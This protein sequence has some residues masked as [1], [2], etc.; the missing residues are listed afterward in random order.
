VAASQEI[1]SWESAP[2]ASSARLGWKA[3]LC[4]PKLCPASRRCWNRPTISWRVTSLAET[5]I[6]SRSPSGLNAT[7]KA[8]HEQGSSVRVC[9][10]AASQIRAVWSLLAVAIQAPS[11]L[12]AA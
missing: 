7:L 10:V 8:N 9:P 11:G 2:L 3:T 6:A 1:T 12:K 4:A 5:P